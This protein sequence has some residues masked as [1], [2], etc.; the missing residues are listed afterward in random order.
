MMSEVLVVG[1]QL[2]AAIAVFIAFVCLQFGVLWQYSYWYLIP[3]IAGSVALF[4]VAFQT[5]QWGFVLLEAVWGLC[6]SGA[7]FN[8]WG[9]QRQYNQLQVLRR[10]APRG[11]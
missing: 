6:R 3:N 10:G 8:G 9:G 5:R 2:A 4:A 11:D 7:L 1:L